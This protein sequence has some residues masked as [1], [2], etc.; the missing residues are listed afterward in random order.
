MNENLKKVLVTIV[1]VVAVG[2]LVAFVINRIGY[3]NLNQEVKEYRERLEQSQADLDSIEAELREAK[4]LNDQ[5]AELITRSRE[6]IDS[7]EQRV[8]NAQERLGEANEYIEE[9][10]QTNNTLGD[11]SN[12]LETT[13]ESAS[14]RLRQLIE[15]LEAEEHN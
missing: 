11:G 9:L 2:L 6:R 15:E 7:L 3:G 8:K 13:I 4:E 10:E 12:E 14:E 5:L 1:I